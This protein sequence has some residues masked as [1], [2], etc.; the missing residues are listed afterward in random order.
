MRSTSVFW[1][2]GSDRRILFYLI[3]HLGVIMSSS[4]AVLPNKDKVV[5]CVKCFNSI[6][7]YE[8]LMHYLT[9][10]LIG[11]RSGNAACFGR[12]YLG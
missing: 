8:H 3:K 9:Q 7:G 4:S 5:V 11:W 10:S 6:I 2:A 1:F 12:D